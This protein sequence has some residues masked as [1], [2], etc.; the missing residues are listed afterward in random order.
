AY[1]PLFPVVVATFSSHYTLC[2]GIMGIVAVSPHTACVHGGSW[3]FYS[4]DCISAMISPSRLFL[5]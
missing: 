4:I 1:I 5:I 2:R 3:R